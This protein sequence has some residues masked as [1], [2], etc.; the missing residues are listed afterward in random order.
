[1]IVTL[2]SIELGLASF[3]AFSLYNDE[4]HNAQSYSFVFLVE[5]V[6]D[7]GWM[8][9]RQKARGEKRRKWSGKLG[10]KQHV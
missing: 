5:S 10:L 7:L 6:Q 3:I 1:M 2:Q 4:T 8:V 9:E